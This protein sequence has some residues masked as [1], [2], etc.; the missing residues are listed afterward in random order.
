MVANKIIEEIRDYCLENADEAI[1]KKYSRFFREG[2]DAYGLTHEKIAFIVKKI[3]NIPNMYPDLI[4][5]IASLL[6]KSGKY[7]ET[8]IAILIVASLKKQF[9]NRIFREINNWFTYGIINWA[10]C[11]ILC[12]ELLSPLL[13]YGDIT[14]KDIEGWKTSPNK[15]QRRAVA[16]S[17]IKLLPLKYDINKLL[18]FIDSMMMDKEKEVHQGLGWFLREAWKKDKQK[19]EPFLI[20]WKDTAP[21]MIY[22]YALEKM[23]K[24]EKEKFRK[25]K[26]KDKL[27]ELEQ[28]RLM[29]DLAKE[30]EENNPN[31]KETDHL[32]IDF[33]STD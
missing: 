24:E 21:R 7:E 29:S 14:I 3:L 8:N 11:D 26:D 19:V 28:T 5:E 18:S 13:I 1:V 9:G 16:V 32:S 25:E 4:F 33:E 20:K 31:Q 15:F 30:T 2:Y 22:Q 23:S 27:K 6:I 12:T 17:I 10:H